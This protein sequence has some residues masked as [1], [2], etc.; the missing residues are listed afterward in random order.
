MVKVS[1]DAFSLVVEY[2]KDDVSKKPVH[3]FEKSNVSENFA[4]FS[5]THCFVNF[6]K[7][8][9]KVLRAPAGHPT[10]TDPQ[11]GPVLDRLF[12]LLL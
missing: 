8:L 9:R 4:C 7:N 10:G 2:Y 12:N 5:K 11:Q 6:S 1:K 3:S